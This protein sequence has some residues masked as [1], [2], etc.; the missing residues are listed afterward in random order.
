MNTRLLKIFL[1]NISLIFI[2]ASCSTNTI[3]LPDEFFELK[4][5]R[6]LTGDDAKDFV[7]KLHFQKVTDLENEIGFYE[8]GKGKA[9]IYITYYPSEKEALSD[10]KKMTEKISPQNSVFI[11][12][13]YFEL[14]GK[15]IYRT[16]GMGQSHYV[17][18]KDNALLWVSVDSIW[19]KEFLEKYLDYLN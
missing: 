15:S 10:E 2:A 4:L 17:F 5:T 3:Y 6:K 13:E 1:T 8:G 11:G 18:T 12:G 19:G 9:L 16:F 14:D 7:N